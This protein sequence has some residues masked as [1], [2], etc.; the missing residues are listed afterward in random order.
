M[1]FKHDL[2][3]IY[4]PVEDSDKIVVPEN[5]QQKLIQSF[6]ELDH[7]GMDRTESRIKL[8]YFWFNMQSDVRTYVQTCES[9]QK[10]KMTRARV[11]HRNLSV[12]TIMDQISLDF[13]GPL[14]RTV[15]DN[16]HILVAVEHFSRWAEAYPLAQPD[17]ISCAQSL[18]NGIFSRFGYCRIIHSDKGSAFISAIMKELSELGQ[19][20]QT[21][22]ARYHPMGT[23]MRKGLK[24]LLAQIFVNV[25]NIQGFNR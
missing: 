5:F 7:A 10:S 1:K 21:F 16:T 11:N 4:D 14:S 3:L 20:I 17:A 13:I 2:L 24:V 12:G 23:S 22:S 9:C 6:H 25:L 15:N 18:H 19:C 8:Y